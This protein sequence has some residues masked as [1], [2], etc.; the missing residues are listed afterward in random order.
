MDVSGRVF[1]KRQKVKFAS[2]EAK[3]KGSRENG[4]AEDASTRACS[5]P[6]LCCDI[7]IQII[8]PCLEGWLP[9]KKEAKAQD[10]QFI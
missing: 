2:A 4:Q 1:W 8:L 3:G 6:Y 5:I 7:Q 9:L 10:S